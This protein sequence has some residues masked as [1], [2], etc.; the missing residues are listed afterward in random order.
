MG[1]SILCE[2]RGDSGVLY[3]VRTQRDQF[4]IYMY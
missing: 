2:A 3:W 1:D 4:H